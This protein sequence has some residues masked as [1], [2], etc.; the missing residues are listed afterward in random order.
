MKLFTTVLRE[1]RFRPINPETNRVEYDKTYWLKPD[2]PTEVPDRDAKIL[3]RQNP[4][5]VSTESAPK[6]KVEKPIKEVA[7]SITPKPEY[8]GAPWKEKTTLPDQTPNIMPEITDEQMKVLKKLAKTKVE[9]IPLKDIRSYGKILG[10]G[11]KPT[12]KGELQRT[13]LLERANE[14]LPN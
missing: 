7:V 8:V 14:L 1:K 13:Q 4:H 3:L 12:L 11:I 9:N 5:L 6:P 10:V 2:E